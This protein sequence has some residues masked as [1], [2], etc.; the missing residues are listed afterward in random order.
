[1]KI[2]Q[3]QLI[4]ISFEYWTAWIMKLNGIA[5]KN[6]NGRTGVKSNPRSRAKS[7]N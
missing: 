6:E 7:E 3:I 5:H 2:A 1:M 4:N